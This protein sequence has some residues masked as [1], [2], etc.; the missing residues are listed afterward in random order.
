MFTT[1]QV[2]T[3]DECSLYKDYEYVI[4]CGNDV[5]ETDYDGSTPLFH[6]STFNVHDYLAEY[7][8]IV[9]MFIENGADIDHR[10]YSGY[11]ALMKSYSD[12]YSLVLIQNGAK[13]E[14]KDNLGVTVSAL[15][16]C[17]KKGQVKSIE[18]IVKNKG[19]DINKPINGNTILNTTFDCINSINYHEA[20]M[21]IMTL[22]K[23]GADVNI[24]DSNGISPLFKWI[25]NEGNSFHGR[26][27][28]KSLIQNGSDVNFSTTYGG[29]DNFTLLHL[30]C[31]TTFLVSRTL[32][33]N[34]ADVNSVTSS[35]TTPIIYL[36]DNMWEHDINTLYIFEE[37]MQYGAK[38]SMINKKGVS[39]LNARHICFE[40]MKVQ[41]CNRIRQERWERRGWILM[42]KERMNYE[43]K[44]N[45]IIDYIIESPEDI[46][47]NILQFI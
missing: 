10:D 19:I 27:V 22:I 7:E 32:L 26:K 45:H 39:V 8:K 42:Y 44:S 3:F 47:K 17:S 43:K 23:L 28:I 21:G 20:V 46:F 11:T 1:P 9:P 37:F 12:L 14:I 15:L 31:S 13:I 41:I 35:G 34:G 33:K 2:S 24:L 36:L 4:N 6:V 18:Y 30:S 29:E 5:N 38:C 16:E 40:E 25:Q